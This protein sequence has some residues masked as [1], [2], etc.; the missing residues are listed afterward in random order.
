MNSY[1]KDRQS[2]LSTHKSP[3]QCSERE[4]YH[5]ILE[6]RLSHFFQ[7][8]TEQI[9]FTPELRSQ[10]LRKIHAPG[11]PQS[12]WLTTCS[13]ALAASLILCALFTFRPVP[14]SAPSSVV[15]QVGPV[16]AVSPELHNGGKLIS[17]DPTEHHLLYQAAHQPGVMY[18]TDLAD[19]IAHNTLVMHDAITAAWAPNGSALVATVAT[20]TTALPLLAMIP[21]GQYMSPLKPEALAATWAP[22]QTQP[23]TYMLQQAG[24]IQ[25][26]RT[27]PDGQ[28]T[29]MQ[30]FWPLSLTPRL[31][32]WSPDGTQLA[33]VVSAAGSVSPTTLTQPCLEIYLLQMH[34][35]HL[36]KLVQAGD[37]SIGALAWSPNSQ[38]LTYEKISA[39]K[40]TTLQ[41][42][43]IHTKHIEFE[44]PIKATLQGW[45]WSPDGRA[46]IYSDGGILR[47][48]E[49]QT[50]HITLPKLTGIQDT[51]FWLKDGRIL[52]LQI[53]GS[54]SQLAYLTP[55][56]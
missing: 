56:H 51:P 32:L 11:F 47:I 24:K 26:W 7:Q 16:E 12:R 52:F 37:F 29:Q 35:L 8:Q 15:Y 27:N 2:Q 39:T 44:V 4:T 13:L 41:T 17:L 48:Y 3:A 53:I 45:S 19:P 9:H 40:Q 18:T 22:S 49:A 10:I 20:D 28:Q 38:S 25:L 54:S 46:L 33:I 5:P 34:N 23:I 55:D 30:A 1:D 31:L 21:T 36:Q 50:A 42:L 6:K 14:I 43:N